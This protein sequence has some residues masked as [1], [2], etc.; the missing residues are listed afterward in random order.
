M[1]FLLFSTSKNKSIF[2]N[3]TATGKSFM[4]IIA[5]KRFKGMLQEQQNPRKHTMLSKVKGDGG[6]PPLILCTDWM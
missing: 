2:L 3:G 1:L 6:N 5:I 4:S